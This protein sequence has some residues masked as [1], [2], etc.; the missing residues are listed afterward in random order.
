MNY[1]RSLPLKIITAL[2][3]RSIP[4]WCHAALFFS[5]IVL[6]NSLEAA[7]HP[8]PDKRIALYFGHYTFGYI[9]IFLEAVVLFSF[10]TRQKPSLCARVVLP[11]AI[12]LLIA[13]VVDLS[14]GRP[15][16]PAYLLLTD[17]VSILHAMLTFF[18]PL[19]EKG[20]TV[21]VRVEIAIFLAC[22][23][24]YFYSKN[25]G[26]VRSIMGTV[27]LYILIFILS[28]L[29]VYPLTVTH[30]DGLY[31]MVYDMNRILVIFLVITLCLVFV[32]QWPGSIRI[33]IHNCRP[34]RVSHYIL[35]FV[36]GYALA[37]FYGMANQFSIDTALRC[38]LACCAIFSAWI[39]SVFINDI[40]DVDID[41]I[42]NPAR[43][44]PAGITD[45]KKMTGIA[46]AMFVIASIASI[47]AGIVPFWIVLSNCAVAQIYSAPPLRIK[48]IPIISKLCISAASLLLVL[49]GFYLAGASLSRFPGEIV[50]YFLVAFTLAVNV[51]DI[52]DRD[53]DKQNGISTLS[54][55]LPPRLGAVLNGL[56]VSGAIVTV[57]LIP[58]VRL[59]LWE[60]FVGSA[61]A[62][63]LIVR[64]NYNDV[65]V[66][67]IYIIVVCSI[68]LY[69]F[70]CTPAAGS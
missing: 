35:V 20:V 32:Q 43:P 5:A 46:T 49:L 25:S 44:L 8:I 57:N 28:I 53:G 18:G 56:F 24:C 39:S 30:A 14:L 7:L 40:F 37:D 26:A 27:A 45:R 19:H 50:V 11:F 59:P 69:L 22:A 65:S 6:R 38:F 68:I 13:P 63:F 9:V 61:A 15:F 21:G 34:W 47:G 42:S 23:A 48:R 4:L 29:P 55:L 3:Q 33:I 2:E 67:K 70:F 60:L 10:I 64:K 12:L 54:A 58:G 66:M 31:R 16:D 62:F 51:I 1:F 36:A 52:K 41:R 17:I